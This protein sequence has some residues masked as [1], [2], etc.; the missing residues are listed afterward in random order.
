MKQVQPFDLGFLRVAA[1]SPQ[2]RVADV[3]FN[4][5]QIA[6][7]MRRAV[8]E[9]IQVLVFPEL[10]LCGYTCADLFFQQL[11]LEQV[12]LALLRLAEI[13]A[14]SDMVVLV[15]APLGQGGKLFNC[16][17]VLRNG[18]ILGVVPKT[19][20]PNTREL[21]EGRWFSSAYA[22]TSATIGIGEVEV[23]FG[24]DL[25]FQHPEKSE[26][27][28]GVEICED[29]WIASPGSG[30]MAQAGAT[31]I[32][33]LS[34]SP[35]ILGKANYRRQLVETQ[36]A[37]CLAAYVYAA[38][39][40]GESS[41]D[42]VFAGHCLIAEN[43]T[44]LT[45]SE[46]FGFADKLISADIDL[47]R[48]TLERRALNS[49]AASPLQGEFRRVPCSPGTW[50]GAELQRPVARNPFVP[51]DRAQ[52]ADHCAE[53]FALQTTALA[54]RLRHTGSRCGVI[55]VSGGLD[56]T[57]AL[58]VLVRAFE[59]L[60]LERSGIIG[61][62]MPG[63]GTSA[64]TRN[65]AEKLI[66]YLGVRKQVIR[67]DAA[68]RQHFSDIGH[69]ENVH[70]ITYE[71]A[72]ARERT[73]ILMD[74]ANQQ[75]GLVIGTGD[76]SELALGWCTYNADHM[77][78]YSV[79]CGVP[80]TL[81]RYMVEWCAQGLFAGP[82][83]E[84]LADI[85]AT[86]ISPELLPPAADGAIQQ[87]TEAQ[88]GPYELHDFFLF[89]VVRNQFAPRKI[90]YLAQTAFA[91]QYSPAQI[92]RWLHYFYTRFFSQQ[93]KRSCA[94]DGPKVGSVALSPRGDWRMPSD[95]SAALWLAEVE[96]LDV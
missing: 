79:N 86:P 46:R 30:T 23:P 69:D 93:F 56:S 4:C 71:N 95:A 55:G 6:A 12:E 50:A 66:D 16:A 5:T 24:E 91:G 90:L 48:L 83:Q 81:V 14:E 78:M 77:S 9:K 33:N 57:L 62:S 72:Q 20:L 92:K 88:V 85:C 73:Q 43:G 52:R 61:I 1:A 82:A 68:V 19:V 80:K 15:G 84:V 59:L 76:L 53:V 22:R 64:R 89:Q 7:L 27:C 58:L 21:S 51:A 29:A 8:A 54:Q 94:P 67:I 36:S 31:L 49:F 26:C 63:F 3:E 47:Q 17:V 44:L 38:A 13:S 65:N 96:A 35:E 11:L 28:L 41:T 32:C 42:M 40:A 10:A 39:G 60:G 45:Q 75:G 74:I 2:L 25:L 34:A 87:L 70:D 18:S 37:R